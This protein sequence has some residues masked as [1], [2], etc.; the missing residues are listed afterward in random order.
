MDCCVRV[1]LP[2][3]VGRLTFR[4]GRIVVRGVLL[5]THVS[6][7]SGDLPEYVMAV[8]GCLCRGVQWAWCVVADKPVV[9]FN[10]FAA[11]R[12]GSMYVFRVRTRDQLVWQYLGFR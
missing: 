10:A 7:C 5:Q 6:L 11:L 2:C 9:A 8:F 4:C 3:C 12:V 1:T